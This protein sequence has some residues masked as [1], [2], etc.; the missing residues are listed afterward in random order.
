MVS[1][2]TSVDT[3]KDAA[4]NPDQASVPRSGR[5]FNVRSQNLNHNS[6]SRYHASQHGAA[7]ATRAHAPR[8][9]VSVRNGARHSHTAAKTGGPSATWCM[10]APP[11]PRH[12]YLYSG[13][14]HDFE[15]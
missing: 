8:N 14:V 7:S 6:R 4:G 15:I 10:C 9:C 3:L 1:T 5:V 11:T 13:A 2:R 12:E